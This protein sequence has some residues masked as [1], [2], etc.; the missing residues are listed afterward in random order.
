M[1]TISI[2]ELK[3]HLSAELKKV[4]A[5]EVLTILDHKRP[6]AEIRPIPQKK[7]TGFVIIKPAVSNEPPKLSGKRLFKGTDE[8]LQRAVLA[9]REEHRW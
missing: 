2:A 1:N 6:V 3:T 9:D 7:N 5:G 4:Q 8:E